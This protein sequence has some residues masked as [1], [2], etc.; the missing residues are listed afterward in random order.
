[1]LRRRSNRLKTWRQSHV[2]RS[3]SVASAGMDFRYGRNTATHT[4][5]L[6]AG[7]VLP[8]L[9]RRL[10]IPALLADPAAIAK[11]R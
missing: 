5:P 2:D 9:P 11:L 7:S 8:D 4:A 1:M 3:K 6:F 10:P